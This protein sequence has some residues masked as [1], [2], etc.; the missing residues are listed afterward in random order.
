[1]RSARRCSYPQLSDWG[2]PLER[3]GGGRADARLSARE[4]AHV[5][6]E[7][8]DLLRRNAEVHKPSSVRRFVDAVL[9]LSDDPRPDNVERYLVA[10][11][12]LE[13]SR[14]R[15]TPRTSRAA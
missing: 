10:S 1:L 13:D 9:A 3:L 12:A 7:H 4:R 14:S 8:P 11:R 6:H 5:R 2:S 15:R